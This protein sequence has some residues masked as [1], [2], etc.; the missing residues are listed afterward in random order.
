MR[1]SE[2]HSCSSALST[3]ASEMESLSSE[4]EFNP[5]LSVSQNKALGD[6]FALKPSRDEC[7][8]QLI[9]HADR[10]KLSNADVFR[11]CA[12]MIQARGGDL[13]QIQISTQTIRKLHMKTE[14]EI[15]KSIRSDYIFPKNLV[16]HF[17]GK[18]RNQFGEIHD[19]LAICVTG[20]GIKSDKILEDVPVPDGTGKKIAQTVHQMIESWKI[21]ENI[22]GLCFDTSANTGLQNGANVCLQVYLDKPLIRLACLH[23][24]LEIIMGA[25]ITLKLGPTSRPREKYFT[26]FEKYFNNLTEEE[27]A[28]ILEDANE[29]VKLLASK[30]KVTSEFHQKVKKLFSSF[31]ETKHSFQR[32]DYLELARKMLVS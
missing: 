26:K 11:F 6:K 4:E 14:T 1:K 16:V 9:P 3:S 13:N 8:K 29:K 7:I 30:D 20:L 31:F 15:D 10:G 28:H 32:G 17:D 5:E 12:A 25:V 21:T 18:R 22:I 24:I 19:F 27:K 23:H 2:F